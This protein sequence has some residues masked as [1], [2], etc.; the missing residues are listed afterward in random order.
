MRCMQRNVIKYS[1]RCR[2]ANKLTKNHVQR[3]K[4]VYDSLR[5]RTSS[6][7]VVHNKDWINKKNKINANCSFE[8]EYSAMA[9]LNSS[10]ICRSQQ[11]VIG[12]Y[13]KLH[14][15][16]SQWVCVCRACKQKT[17]SAYASRK[18]NNIRNLF[19]KRTKCSRWQRPVWPVNS[20][21]MCMLSAQSDDWLFLMLLCIALV[22]G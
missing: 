8:Y 10:S 15:F 3:Q 4:Y 17:H 19:M 11:V 7:A 16:T 13:T 18:T 9:T 1:Y 6:V 2:A 20:T 14:Y 5:P 21:A 22:I 12:E